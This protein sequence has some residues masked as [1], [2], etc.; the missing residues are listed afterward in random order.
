[1]PPHHS[2]NCSM[3]FL[4]PK[5]ALY[6]RLQTKKNK[7]YV[8]LFRQKHEHH[9]LINGT[10]PL[11]RLQLSPDPAVEMAAGLRIECHWPQPPPHPIQT[12]ASYRR[13]IVY[14]IVHWSQTP[15]SIH[16]HVQIVSN[17]N[18]QH[19][20]VIEWRVRWN[21]LI[22]TCGTTIA[23]LRTPRDNPEILM[24]HKALNIHWLCTQ[25]A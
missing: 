23:R 6:W 20:G 14:P 22:E 18:S 1:M 19:N 5:K 25:I 2:A 24:Q 9:R 4:G 16:I 11:L 12:P 21:E 3:H 8:L 10:L 15:P 7:P 13:Q 17:S